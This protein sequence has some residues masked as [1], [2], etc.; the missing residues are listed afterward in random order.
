[1]SEENTTFEQIEELRAKID[2]ID[3][4]IVVLLNERQKQALAIRSLKPEVHLGL[5]DPRREEEIINGLQ[6]YNEGPLYPDNLREIYTTI[7]KVSKE[8]PE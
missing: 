3:H 4:Q 7:L 8:V 1:M 2:E 6:A 5:Y